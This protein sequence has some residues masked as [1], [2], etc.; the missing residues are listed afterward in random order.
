LRETY[1]IQLLLN[2]LQNVVLP[3]RR[4]VKLNPLKGIIAVLSDPL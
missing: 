1:R 2:S 3:P 4:G